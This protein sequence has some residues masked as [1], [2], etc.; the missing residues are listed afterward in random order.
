MSPHP[1]ANRISAC[2]SS[3]LPARSRHCLSALAIPPRF[4][5]KVVEDR[6]T[7]RPRNRQSPGSQHHENRS[8]RPPRPQNH[9]H[10]GPACNPA[11]TCRSACCRRSRG[12]RPPQ[13]RGYHRRTSVRALPSTRSSRV[14]LSRARR[15]RVVVPRVR[16]IRRR[17]VRPR[18]SGGRDRHFAGRVIGLGTRGIK[19]LGG[20][21][22]ESPTEQQ[23]GYPSR[24][25]QIVGPERDHHGDPRH[26]SAKHHSCSKQ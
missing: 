7:M 3:N 2:A 24:R 13:G 9:L 20:W 10:S 22:L 19:S 1:R 26:E 12:R 4:P 25:L 5:L 14:D 18:R 21:S 23:H 16:R 17:F 11:G 8:P 6:N 15:G